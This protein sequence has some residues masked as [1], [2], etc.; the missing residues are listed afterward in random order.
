ME[1]WEDRRWRNTAEVIQYTVY[2]VVL[3]TMSSIGLELLIGINRTVL[4]FFHDYISDIMYE[5][6]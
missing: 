4:P 1:E 5:R 6:L 3:F 2:R